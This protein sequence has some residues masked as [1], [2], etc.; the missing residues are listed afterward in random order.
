MNSP[1]VHEI[2]KTRSSVIFK[3]KFE[4]YSKPY[5]SRFIYDVAIIIPFNHKS[6]NLGKGYFISLAYDLSRLS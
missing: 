3:I 5:I 1:N 6:Q 2:N 4:F